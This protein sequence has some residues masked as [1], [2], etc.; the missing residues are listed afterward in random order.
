MV[1]LTH[2]KRYSDFGGFPAY[3]LITGASKTEAAKRLANP[4]PQRHLQ[5]L[6]VS[7]EPGRVC[8]ETMTFRQLAL[9]LLEFSLASPSTV[10]NMDRPMDPPD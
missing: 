9:E 5:G 8:S 10:H 6:N 1:Q 4:V 2:P 7:R 3:F